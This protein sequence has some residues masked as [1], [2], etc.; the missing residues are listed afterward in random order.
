MYTSNKSIYLV[1]ILKETTRSCTC[2][3]WPEFDFGIFLAFKY[4]LNKHEIR[5]IVGSRML[6]I[7]IVMFLKSITGI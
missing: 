5:L 1:V 6:N 3:T 2:K 4:L 7:L